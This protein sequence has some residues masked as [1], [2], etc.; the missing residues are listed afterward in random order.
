MDRDLPRQLPDDLDIAPHR[1]VDGLQTLGR[2]IEIGGQSA[3]G[4]ADDIACVGV[5]VVADVHRCQRDQRAVRQ[6]VALGEI[7]PHGACAHGQRDVVDGDPR[8]FRDV[9]YPV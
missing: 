6:R 2:V 8:R 4:S 1:H 9:S 5:L 7:P 3:D